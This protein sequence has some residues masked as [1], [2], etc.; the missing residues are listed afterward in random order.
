MTTFE[1]TYNISS[2]SDYEPNDV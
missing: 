2:S 1:V